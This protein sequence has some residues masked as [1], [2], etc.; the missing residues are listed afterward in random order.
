MCNRS[1]LDHNVVVDVYQN[2]RPG[3]RAVIDNRKKA[4][5]IFPYSPA[6]MEEIAV[7]LRSQP[8]LEKAQ[9]MVGEQIAL[10]ADLS[11]TWEILPAF[12]N[13]GSSQVVQEHPSDCMVRVMHNY[14]HT[15][16]SEEIERFQL[17]WKSE[18]AFNAVQDEFGPPIRVGPGIELFP[19]KRDRLGIDRG[20]TN[21]APERVF[22]DA[23]VRKALREKL[24]H[25]SWKVETMPMGEDLM[26]SHIDRQNVVN[27]L[28][29][30][31]EQACYYAD[32]FDKHRSH[33][34]DVSHAIYAA[35][36]DIFVTGDE[37]YAKRVRAVYH[38]LGL[39][40]RVVQTGDFIRNQGCVSIE[41][42]G[43]DRHT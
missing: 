14:D 3:L 25:Y 6:H 33:L 42:Q 23:G 37:R 17:C 40:T 39:K 24:W 21:I 13:A 34:H 30:V 10:V 31:L 4:G 27:I 8:D 35:E 2:R 20:I 36:A 38:F 1:Y 7:I 43:K 18:K 29:K 9:K 11:D 5:D 26:R 41:D 19:E 15:L 28:L 12:Q 32:S 22:E 16:S